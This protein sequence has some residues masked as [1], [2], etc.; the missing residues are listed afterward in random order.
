[1]LIDQL[2]AVHC[3]IIPGVSLAHGKSRV[4]KNRRDGLFPEQQQLARF[5]PLVDRDLVKLGWKLGFD[6]RFKEMIC[7][8]STQLLLCVVLCQAV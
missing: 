6:Q 3:G 8:G 5:V 2:P 7:T 1:M 4:F